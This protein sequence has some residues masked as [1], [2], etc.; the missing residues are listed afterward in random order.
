MQNQDWRAQVRGGV[1]E[2]STQG[3]SELG[4]QQTTEGAGVGEATQG[5]AN[6]DA[7]T[8]STRDDRRESSR[9]GASRL[10]WPIL[11]ALAA[12]AVIVAIVAALSSSGDRGVRG[13]VDQGAPDAP[14]NEKMRPSNAR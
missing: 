7:P 14:A 6:G 10:W 12:L 13:P 4:D 9:S 2:A 3:R 8:R 11:A 5:R 1:G